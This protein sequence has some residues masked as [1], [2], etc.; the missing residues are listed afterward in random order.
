MG[1]TRDDDARL[2]VFCSNCGCRM[3]CGAREANGPAPVFCSEECEIDAG[4]NQWRP[5]PHYRAQYDYAC[6]YHD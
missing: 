2:E 4:V 3:D 1:T 5:D 6:G